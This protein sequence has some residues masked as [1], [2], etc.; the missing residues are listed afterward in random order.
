MPA[1]RRY[2]LPLPAL[3]SAAFVAFAIEADNVAEMQ[4]PHTT[5]SF[6]GQRDTVWLPSLAMW[7]N[8][9]RGLGE[10]GELTV[11]ELARRVR[12]GTNL[13]GM[14]RWG[15][16]TIDGIGRVPRRPGGAGRPHAMPGSVLALTDR[17][18]AAHMVWR[19][20][21][22]AIEARWRDR[23]GSAAVDRLR[24]A[25]V[26][27][28]EQIA[29][30]LPDFLPI[31]SPQDRYPDPPARDAGEREHDRRLPLISLL[32]RVLLRFELDCDHGARLPLALWSDLVRVLDP[33]EPV[34]VRELPALTGVSKEAL[35]MMIGRL[36][37]AGLVLRDPPR[38]P[39]RGKQLRLTP[40]RG[41]RASDAV[42]QRIERTVHAWE[43]TYGSNC[44][45]E[46]QAAALAIAGDGTG[47]GS[48][49]F[50]G[51]E[52]PA[53]GWRAQVPPPR[54]LPWHP[55][56]LHRGGYPDGS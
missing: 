7:F 52:P 21:P 30:A 2:A 38:S 17:G 12:M 22:E 25:L 34:A 36:E 1:V 24:E 16:I 27:I 50:A 55:R 37:K 28:T 29:A 35:N 26:P 32:S 41:V 44:V 23:F 11:A 3:L 43:Q 40:D 53:S 51:L 18:R 9:V 54:L 48:P 8:C 31:S 10:G 15:F 39:E 49:L 20:L 47:E 42:P 4:L 45:V 5:T 56:V 14:R 19:P 13:D 33:S 46:L 6:G